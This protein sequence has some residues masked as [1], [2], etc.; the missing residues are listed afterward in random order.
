MYELL[1]NITTHII[2]AYF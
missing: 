2:V 1:S